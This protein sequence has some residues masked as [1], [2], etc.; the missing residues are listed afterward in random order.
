M[1]VPSELAVANV[2]V[3]VQLTKRLFVREKLAFTV[4]LRMNVLMLALMS[5]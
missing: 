3:T 2:I 1:K 5:A 4:I